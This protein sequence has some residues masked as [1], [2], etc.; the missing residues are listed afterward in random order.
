MFLHHVAAVCLYPGFLFG[1]MMGVGVVLAW[2]HDIGDIF[3]NTCRLMKAFDWKI[4]TLITYLMLLVAWAYTRLYIL[5]IYFYRTATELRFPAELSHFQPLVALELV[6]LGVMQ[7][8][9][10]WW[11]FL[12]LRVGYRMLF[13]GEISESDTTKKNN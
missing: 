4:P 9:H 13:S 1:N 11:Y 5:P 8:L 2:L 10:V 3:L 7:V 12:F 6:F